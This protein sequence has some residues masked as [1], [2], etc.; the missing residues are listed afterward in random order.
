MVY[1][2]GEFSQFESVHIYYKVIEQELCA[3]KIW[4]LL[5]I[6]RIFAQIAW[7]HGNI[8][9]N[10]V[11][12]RF[13]GY[14]YEKWKLQKDKQCTCIV[15]AWTYERLSAAL[16]NFI[17]RDCGKMFMLWNASLDMTVKRVGIGS[18]S[19]EPKGPSTWH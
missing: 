13:H 4:L 19:G 17:K 2:V 9:H 6:K 8:V 14:V 7:P 1:K 16:I 12:N 3:C 10:S 18:N 5:R 11:Y 15:C